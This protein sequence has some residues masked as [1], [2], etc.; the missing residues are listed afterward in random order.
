MD[1]SQNLD[2]ERDDKICSLTASGNQMDLDLIRS[3]VKDSRYICS[4]CGR[5]TGHAE[6]LCD[7]EWL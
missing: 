3:L 6:N 7:P 5:T 4:A 1:K 2:A